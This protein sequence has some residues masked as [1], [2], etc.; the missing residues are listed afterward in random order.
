MAEFINTID[1]L[2]DEAVMDSII[3]RTITEFKDDVLT[4]GGAYA[5]SKCT[6]LLT[7][8]LPNLT[9][10]QASMFDGCS[11]L[12]TLNL[13]KFKKVSGG[14]YLFNLPKLENIN[15]P[16]LVGTPNWSFRGCAFEKIV[17]PAM[18]DHGTWSFNDNSKLKIADFSVLKSMNATSWRNNTSLIALVL[19]NSTVVTMMDSSALTNSPIATG[20][21]YIYV[22]RVLVDSY[23]AAANW[24]TYAAQFRALEDYTIDGTITGELDETKIQ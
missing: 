1:V 15:C 2:G 6:A 3:N 4:S 14:E 5:F 13:P 21:G 12:S 9:T 7:V 16:S 24:S 8:D 19:R 11:N 23:E 18:T 20:A 10:M 22:P 17:L